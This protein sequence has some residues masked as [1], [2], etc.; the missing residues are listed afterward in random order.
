MLAEPSYSYSP[1]QRTHSQALGAETKAA[2]LYPSYLRKFLFPKWEGS[3]FQVAQNAF[4]CFS[5]GIIQAKAQD[6]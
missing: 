6:S 5:D 4:C 1:M 3:F 2:E